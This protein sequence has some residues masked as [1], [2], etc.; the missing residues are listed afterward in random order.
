MKVFLRLKEHRH[1]SVLAV[2]FFTILW[3]GV[4]IAFA[5]SIDLTD[6]VVTWA[7]QKYGDDAGKRVE[8]WRSLMQDNHDTGEVEKLKLVNDFFNQIPYQSDAI[9]W[10]QKD[11][12]A[13]PLELLVREGGDCEDYS[14]AKYFTLKEMGVAD[15]KLRIMYVKSV[16][17][18]QSHMVLTY[19]PNPSAIP[20]VLDN[21]N[22]QLLSASS[23][24]DLTPV[25]SFNA[26]G[27]WLAKSLGK[28]KKWALPNDSVYGR[29]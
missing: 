6:E 5:E 26:D 23:R 16:E 17:L 24:L 15:E 10:D 1:G 20:K 25:Y 9:L 3:L 2:L 29:K 19:Y 13:T 28:G 11:Y 4:A 7:K 27:L 22:P 21:L 12:W 14:I 18:N 8:S